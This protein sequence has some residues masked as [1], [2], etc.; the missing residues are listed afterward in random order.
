MQ[1]AELIPL[2]I[3]GADMSALPHDVKASL[4]SREAFSGRGGFRS[5]SAGAG[6]TARFFSKK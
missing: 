6:M 4:T 5:Y 2:K 1:N 3:A